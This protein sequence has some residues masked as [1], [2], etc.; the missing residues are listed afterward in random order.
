MKKNL[1]MVAFCAIMLGSCTPVKFYSDPELTKPTGLKLY[2]AKP[3]L[4]AER[5]AESGRIVKS[6]IIYLPDLSSPQFMAVKNAPGA[7]KT[8]LKL[9]DGILTSFGFEFEQMLPETIESVAT[10]LS[11]TAGAVEDIEGLRGNESLKAAPNTMQLYEIVIEPQR[12]WLRE[13]NT[14]KNE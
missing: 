14:V 11:K 7:S 5:E 4:L 6:T 13:I 3:F 8:D 9:N 12:T 1:I 2:T 10:L